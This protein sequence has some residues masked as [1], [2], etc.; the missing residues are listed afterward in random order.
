MAVI[1]ELSSDRSESVLHDENAHIA[2]VNIQV[3][4]IVEGIRCRSR[5]RGGGAAGEGVGGNITT[6]LL[7]L[8]C[9]QGLQSHTLY[10]RIPAGQSVPAGTYG[11]QVMVTI[12][13]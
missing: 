5:R 7:G 1:E 2:H 3:S 6:S 10:A 12:T 13:Y 4:V 8:V 11:D 9:L